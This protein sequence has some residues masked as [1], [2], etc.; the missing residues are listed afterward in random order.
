VSLPS[1]R[2][3]TVSVAFRKLRSTLQPQTHPGCSLSA[4]QRHETAI[5]L[6]AERARRRVCPPELGFTVWTPKCSSECMN[7][8]IVV[9]VFMA[10]ALSA[11][12]ANAQSA[13]DD[14]KAAGSD[15]KEAGK[16]TGEAAKKTG[17]ATKKESKSVAH[18]S[19]KKVRKGAEKVEDKTN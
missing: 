5:R 19:A 15:V 16:A 18:K 11:V 12:G 6:G 10:A 14:I 2:E 9:S 3:V 1:S 8:K 13:K 4:S 17:S 7:T